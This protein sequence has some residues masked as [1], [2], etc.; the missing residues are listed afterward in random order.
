[1][2]IGKV[3]FIDETKEERDQLE[4]HESIPKDRLHLALHQCIHYKTEK[5][6]NKHG[7]HD[8]LAAIFSKAIVTGQQA[9]HQ[10]IEHNMC[11]S[12]SRQSFFKML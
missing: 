3:H 7:S 9:Q 12:I 5:F 10:G 8:K 4:L 11:P 2:G 1:M 6:S